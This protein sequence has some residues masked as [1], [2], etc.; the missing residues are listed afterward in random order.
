MC[1]IDQPGTVR[2]LFTSIN[3][4]ERWVFHLCY[5]PSK[6]EE[7]ED[8][9]SERFA[10]LI[11]LPSACPMSRWTSRA[12][13]PG[14]R[15]CVSQSSSSTAVSS[16]PV[17]RHPRCHPGADRA[18]TRASPTRTTSRGSWQLSRAGRPAQLC[19]RRTTSN[20]CQ[21]GG[22]SRRSR[23]LWR[24]RRVCLPSREPLGCGHHRPAPAPARRVRL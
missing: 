5:D 20:G 6:G 24:T 11:K 17:T 9:S 18:P 7:V 19:W 2:G 23:R 4:R 14:S 13:S 22:S 1:S 3:N 16:W 21:S 10:E 15:R 8:F 12:S